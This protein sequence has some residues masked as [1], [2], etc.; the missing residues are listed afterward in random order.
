MTGKTTGQ[1]AP[2]SSLHDLVC[3]EPLLRQDFCFQDVCLDLF[4]SETA[5]LS[6][7]EQE[8]TIYAKMAHPKRKLEWLAGRYVAKKAIEDLA[9]TQ[10]EKIEI[11][12]DSLGAPIAKLSPDGFNVVVS[13]SHSGRW[14]CAAARKLPP[15]EL[16]EK[17][18]YPE[19][20][21]GLGVDLQEVVSVHEK[22]I[23]RVCS[24]DEIQWVG[25]A[26]DHWVRFHTLWSIKEAF[27]KAVPQELHTVFSEIQTDLSQQQFGFEKIKGWVH[28]R[29]KRANFF[30]WPWKT[31][32]EQ[33]VLS[34]CWSGVG[35]HKS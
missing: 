4:S 10:F 32:H 20:R 7:S 23:E 35:F 13:I 5:F 16:D 28:S 31:G 26:Q 9:R 30:T 3:S 11:L 6:L 17:S 27:V 25:S 2:L 8:Q 24:N 22:I 33:Y 15:L 34:V 21:G 18:E 1:K 12:S 19:Y 14:A 29:G